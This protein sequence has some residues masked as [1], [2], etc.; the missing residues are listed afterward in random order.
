MTLAEFWGSNV[1]FDEP[2]CCCDLVMLKIQTLQL[3]YVAQYV[4]F[5]LN[6]G[7]LMF[8]LMS[9]FVAMLR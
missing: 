8:C 4:F 1:L 6:F 7:Y 5:S 3:M 2:F 9:P